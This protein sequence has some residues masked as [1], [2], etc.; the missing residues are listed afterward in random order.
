[1]SGSRNVSVAEA[2]RAPHEA[3]PRQT[4]LVSLRHP[5]AL[6]VDLDGTLL[7]NGGLGQ[8][9]RETCRFVAGLVN[10]D[11]E[12]LLEANAEVRPRVWREYEMACWLGEADGYAASRVAWCRAM[13]ACGCSDDSVVEQTLAYYRTLARDAFRLYADA[14]LFLEYAAKHKLPMAVVTN[15]PSDVQRDKIEAIDVAKHVDVIVISGERGV[16][17]PNPSIFRL[18]LDEL[19]VEPEDAWC[20]GDSLATDVAGACAAGMAA[21]WVNRFEEKALMASPRPHME[22]TS[23]AALPDLLSSLS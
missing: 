9:A 11:P 23:L 10:V 14:V 17:K 13:E 19:G 15:G 8:V 5:E 2:S 1:L 4:G 22:L 18:T 20:V 3:F 6:L 7:D 21:V 12:R 16:A